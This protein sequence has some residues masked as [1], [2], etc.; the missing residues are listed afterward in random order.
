MKE[1]IL[2]VLSELR[3]E[4]D[5]TEPGHDFVEEG[6]I[7]SLDIVSIVDVA[8]EEFC[9]SIPGT[10]ILPENFKDIDAIVRIITKYRTA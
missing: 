4:Y 2:Q 5:F 6:M 3:P 9:A 8:E 10:E 1:R 7:D